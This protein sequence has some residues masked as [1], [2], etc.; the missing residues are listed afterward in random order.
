MQTFE[1]TTNGNISYLAERRPYKSR[2]KEKM[3]GW[4]REYYNELD[5]KAKIAWKEEVDA[6]EETLK[7]WLIDSYMLSGDAINKENA[8]ERKDDAICNRPQG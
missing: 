2:K 8:R 4:I 7:K 1:S 3:I 6:V 5:T